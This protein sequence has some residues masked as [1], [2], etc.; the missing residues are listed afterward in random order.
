MDA[1][2]LAMLRRAAAGLLALGVFAGSCALATRVQAQEAAPHAFWTHNP[3]AHA[4]GAPERVRRVGRAAGRAALSAGAA[5]LRQRAP[6]LI[7][8]GR[9][10]DVQ[11]P[12]PPPFIRGRLV[13]ARNVNRF[14]AAMGK[15]GTGSA[16][17]ASFLALPHRATRYTPGAVQVS[18]R[19]GGHHAEIVA[20][21]GLCWNPSARGQRWALVSCYA[22][23]NVIAWRA[24]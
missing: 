6:E 21:G 13:C 19:R 5:Y 22:R 16:A 4:R 20:G 10:V 3:P 14:L 23:R 12:P 15:P 7:E 1:L 8:T 11:L 18:R 2:S 24:A 9:R 17:A